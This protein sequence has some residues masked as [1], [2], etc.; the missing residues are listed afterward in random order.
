MIE[1][2]WITRALRILGFNEGWAI[3]GD[4]IVVWEHDE[5]QPTLDELREALNGN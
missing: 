4:D 1:E 3:Q 2:P 5:P